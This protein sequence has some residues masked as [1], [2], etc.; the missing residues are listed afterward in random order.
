ML[1]SLQACKF[2]I[3]WDGCEGISCPA[4]HLTRL[5][6]DNASRFMLGRAHL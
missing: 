2:V 4:L 6:N 3:L 5:R 1:R